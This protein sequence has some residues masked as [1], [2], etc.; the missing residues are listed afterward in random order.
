MFM[1]IALCTYNG[2]KFLSDQL[3][4]YIDQTRPPDELVVCDDQSEDNTVALLEDFQTK[5][6]FSVRIISNE[7]NLGVTKNF[8]KAITHCTGDIIVLSDQDDCW[9]PEKLEIMEKV[10]LQ[11]SDIGLVYSNLKIVDED[12]QSQDITMFDLIHFND[13]RQQMFHDG[14]GFELLLKRNYI[15][16]AGM[17]FRA[18]YRQNILPISPLWIHD[19]WISIVLSLFTKFAIID[20]TLTYYRQHSANE[21]GVTNTRGPKLSLLRK[22]RKTLSISRTA[23]QQHATRSFEFY[24]QFKA[25][26]SVTV[27]DEDYQIPMHYMYQKAEHLERRANLPHN[28]IARIPTIISELMNNR[29]QM[30]SVN[31]IYSALRDLLSIYEK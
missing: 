24:E 18:S 21:I 7:N 5:V 9:H 20:E 29:Y 23:Y 10:F 16:G 28:R 1:S 22:F 8:E 13:D 14:K 2:E 17:A 4:S 15:T 30:Y 3:Q 27:V 11:D 25:R 12:L 31:G 26:A 6:D 19:E